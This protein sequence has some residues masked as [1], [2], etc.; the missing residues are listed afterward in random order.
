MGGLVRRTLPAPHMHT[1]RRRR[2][3][4][5]APRCPRHTHPARRL[6]ESLSL[7]HAATVVLSQLFQKRQE[8]VGHRVP[9][10]LGELAEGFE[11]V[12]TER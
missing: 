4:A 10:C 9:Q 1:L 5:Q 2:C 6:Q 12:G 7:S 8:L 3:Y 11:E